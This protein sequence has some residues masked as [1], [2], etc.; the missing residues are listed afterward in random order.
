MRVV[1]G[2]GIEN[3]VPDAVCDEAT[4]FRSHWAGAGGWCA[5]G[6]AGESRCCRPRQDSCAAHGCPNHPPASCGTG[7]RTRPSAAPGSPAPIGSQR[8][9]SYRRKCALAS[10]SS[11]GTGI[12]A[13]RIMP[14]DR[15]RSHPGSRSPRG[16]ERADCGFGSVRAAMRE[17][18]RCGWSPAGSLRAASGR[19]RRVKRSRPALSGA[20][21]ALDP[22][23]AEDAAAGRGTTDEECAGMR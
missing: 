15:H 4:A 18:C 2:A 21:S 16:R 9:G 3:S 5:P 7:A 20:L 22:V 1:D 13:T 19:L 11:N 10:S 23:S 17:R 6:A 12:G 8:T 14:S